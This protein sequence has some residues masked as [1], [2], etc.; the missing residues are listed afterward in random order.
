[1]NYF[2]VSFLIIVFGFIGFLAVHA[3]QFW[4][5]RPQTAQVRRPSNPIAKSESDR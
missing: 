5:S 3:V 2:A 4:R 1:M